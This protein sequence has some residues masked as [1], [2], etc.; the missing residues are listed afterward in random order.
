MR[1]SR[2]IIIV[3]RCRIVRS[4]ARPRCLLFKALYS[5]SS[6]KSLPKGS[7]TVSRTAANIKT[8]SRLQPQRRPRRL[9]WPRTSP[10]HGG[11]TGSNPVGDAKPFNNLQVLR[12]SRGT[13][14]RSRLPR[15]RE[16][17]GPVR[18][19]KMMNPK[20]DKSEQCYRAAMLPPRRDGDAC[21]Q[22]EPL[23]HPK[24][25]SR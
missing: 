4:A 20:G 10:F 5:I 11:N 6:V 13:L 3:M 25:A 24:T 16:N 21:R 8:S 18:T 22:G 1:P 19:L 2:F 23:S 12:F 7:L 14:I 17:S 15:W 9:A